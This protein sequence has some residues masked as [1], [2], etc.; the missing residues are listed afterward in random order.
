[1]TAIMG[2][3]GPAPSGEK[4]LPE[5][6]GLD[7]TRGLQRIMGNHSAYRNLL[8]MYLENQAHVPRQIR[9]SLDEGDRKTA[10]R[11]AHS[12][13]GVSANSG[14]PMSRSLRPPWK[15]RSERLSLA[16]RSIMP[17]MP[18]RWRRSILSPS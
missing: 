11:L 18:F 13:K 14:P 2:E 4:A 15:N 7:A 6:S 1:M 17:W 16:R 3:T 8:R 12:A 5:I 10:L 9:L